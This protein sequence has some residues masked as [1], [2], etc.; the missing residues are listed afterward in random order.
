MSLEGLVSRSAIGRVWDLSFRPGE[1]LLSRFS[2]LDQSRRPILW[3][4]G[5]FLV[6]AI[7]AT[8]IRASNLEEGRI[9][10]MARGAVEDGHWLTPFIYG[11]RFPERPVLL[12]WITAVFGEVTGGVTLWSLRIPHLCFFLAGALMIYGLLR[13]VAGKSAAIF[14]ALCWISMPVVAPKFI[15][16]EPDIVLSAL[17]FAA[18]FV[19]WQGTSGKGMTAGR[20]LGVSVLI[21]LAGLTKGPQP[22]AYFTF[23]VGAYILLKQRNQIAAFIVAHLFAGLII[24]G[25]YATVYQPNDNDIEAWMAHSRLSNKI[26]SLEMVRYHLDF[27]KSLAVEFLP[28]TILIGSA[29]AIVARSWR[30]TRHD[31]MLAV[32]LYSVACTLVLVF[33]PGKVAARYAMPA[34]M[35]LAVV[36]GLMFENWRYSHPKVIVSALVVT[37][38][39]FAGLLVRGWVAMPFWPHLFQESQIA[40]NAISSVLQQS[41]GPLYVVGDSTE[42][43]ML[44]YVRGKVRAV[45]IDDI[46]QLK[47]SAV[48]VLLPEEKLALSQKNPQM[49]LIDRANIVSQRR[50]YRVVVLQP[51]E[52]R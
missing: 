52:T 24:G 46:A 21:A 16:S 43:N 50:P 39:I 26:T 2:R 34:T 8:I 3:V 31:L 40:G 41:P 5:L 14:G 22:V 9:L 7:P 44:G 48:A 37:Y 42:H 1:W 35:T 30:S 23:G 27:V 25:W 20:W 33:W 4:T 11:E 13:S 47:T 38:L 10:A 18:F 45:A 12:S 49:K 36:C 51:A 28:G 29:V 17:L 32:V 19:W 15:N 6:Q